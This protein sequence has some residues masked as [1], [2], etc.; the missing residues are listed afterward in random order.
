MSSKTK[1]IPLDGE[2]RETLNDLLDGQYNCGIYGG[3][4][5]KNRGKQRIRCWNQNI[6]NQR[7]APEEE[8][9]LMLL[10]TERPRK[11]TRNGVYLNIGG[12]K[13][14]YRSDDSWKI[15]QQMV[16]LRYD[17]EDIGSVRVYEADTD[18]YI[19]TWPMASSTMMAFRADKETISAGMKHLRMTK[20]SI[21]AQVK[22]KKNQVPADER[23]DVLDVQRWAAKTAKDGMVIVQPKVLTP[24]R[25][26]EPAIEPLPQ[27]VGIETVE[28]QLDR[29]SANADKRKQRERR[30]THG[31]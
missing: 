28:I 19:A 3:T 26:Q 18:R 27:A 14:Y 2:I 10:R 9:N 8:L 7:I 4:I 12:E 30:W 24:V 15:Q 22:A 11:V 17:P 23:V 20:K 6:R 31:Q 29:M 16:Y 5:V 13:I 1:R 21:K 25:A